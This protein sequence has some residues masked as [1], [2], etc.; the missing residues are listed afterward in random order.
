M[1]GVEAKSE[2]RIR[3]IFQILGGTVADHQAVGGVVPTVASWRQIS[4]IHERRC[5]MIVGR[6][7]TAVDAG[8]HKFL[9]G[10]TQCL[11]LL[12]HYDGS[13]GVVDSDTVS[14]H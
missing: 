4:F 7:L 6:R 10:V 14:G 8:E 13:S 5:V 3:F 12:T 2:N 1:S 11:S 9:T